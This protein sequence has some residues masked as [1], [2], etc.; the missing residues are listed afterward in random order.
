MVREVSLLLVDVEGAAREAAGKLLISVLGKCRL[1]INNCRWGQTHD[2]WSKCERQVQRHSVINFEPE[3]P[4]FICLL[5]WLIILTFYYAKQPLW[6]YMA[7]G[8][9]AWLT[10]HI[11]QSLNLRKGKLEWKKLFKVIF[12]FFGHGDMGT[13]CQYSLPKADTEKNRHWVREVQ[14]MDDPG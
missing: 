8:G 7:K 3:W 9:V 12:Q 14:G 13:L 1:K 6:F 4:S 11:C 2:W 5:I 10:D